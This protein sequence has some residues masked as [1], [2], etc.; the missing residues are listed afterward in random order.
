MRRISLALALVGAI[1][2]TGC[3]AGAK[4]SSDSGAA[5]GVSEDTIKVTVQNGQDGNTS[6]AIKGGYVTSNPP[7]IDCGVPPHNSCDFAFPAKDAAGNPTTIVLTANP[8]APNAFLQWAGDCQGDGTC[9][10]TGYSDK[11]IV[12]S[13]GSYYEQGAHPNWSA[14]NVHASKYGTLDCR[15]CHGANLQGVGIAISCVQC[16]NGT[17]QVTIDLEGILDSDTVA[18]GKHGEAH[19]HSSNDCARCHAGAGFR[20]YI[21]ADGTDSN[22]DALTYS[23]GGSAATKRG[24]DAT[25]FAEGMTCGMCHNEATVLGGGDLDRHVFASGVKLTMDGNTAIC[26]QCHDGARPGYEVSKVKA[27]LTDAANASVG[28]DDQLVKGNGV[29]RAHYLAAAATLF[30]GEASGYYE[31]K[32]GGMGGTFTM[33]NIYTGRNEH[34]GK[35]ACTDCHNAHTGELPRDSEIKAKCGVCHFNEAGAP[36][37]S[38]VELEEIRQYGFEG[39]I[40]GDL[41]AHES[42]RDEINGLGEVLYSTIRA[43][44]TEVAGASIC[45]ADNRYYYDNGQFGATASN[46]VCEE[47]E[48]KNQVEASCSV[49][50]PGEYKDKATCEAASGV[51]TDAV[52]NQYTRFTPRLLAA[53]FN[54]LMFQSDRGA[55][56]HNPRYVIEVLSDTILDLNIGLGASAITTPVKRAFNG[57]F[58]GAEDASP[59]A[60]MTYH[61]ASNPPMGFTSGACYQCHGGTAGLA[62]YLANPTAPAWPSAAPEPNQSSAYTAYQVNA[63]QCSVC[64]TYGADMKGIKAIETAYFPGQKAID[65]E[66]TNGV[67]LVAAADAP[68]GFTL[69]ATCHSGRENMAS[70]V[71]KIGD[72][73]PGDFSLSVSNPHYLGAAGIMLGD[74]AKMMFQYP[75]KSYTGK[76]AF[77]NAETN[78]NAPGPHGSPH[79][80]ACTGCHDPKG[81]AHTFEITVADMTVDD[82]ATTDVNEAGKC[83]ECHTLTGHGDYSLLPIEHH[84]NT[85]KAEVLAAIRAYATTNK[86]LIRTAL[87]NPDFETVCFNATKHPYFYVETSAGCSTSQFNKADSKLLAAMF[88]Y[89]WMDK[90]KGAWAHNEFYVL[91]VAYDTIE[92]LDGTPTFDRPA[93]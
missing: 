64:H 82:P 38:L 32:G 75:D 62:E 22:V 79:G 84:F 54:Y 10:L 29:V 33:R 24:T 16:H 9:T 68:K 51:W 41:N 35:A 87:S 21:G 48:F 50:N 7:G 69:C 91:Q 14:P 46:G 8:I 71:K 13:F 17:G 28:P 63:L 25:S 66:N 73:E 88:N 74:E 65:A 58:G 90:A 80:A 57:H 5:P 1:A 2:A 45:A 36:V 11:Y 56:A 3:G 4:K 34:G 67:V 19:G 55:W 18:P 30:G 44:A 49:G 77:W 92:D 70:I 12:A 81:T 83:G 37:A 85:A 47:G 78:G 89:L 52:S 23:I 6:L 42:L 60:A 76:P 93:P 43:Y 20:D 61:A 26:S 15:K 39:D 53:G 86:D 59:Y 40:D 72:K 27:V 31:Y